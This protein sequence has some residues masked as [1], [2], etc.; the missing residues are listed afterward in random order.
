MVFC[1][2]GDYSSNCPIRLRSGLT[3]SFD[4][5]PGVGLRGKVNIEFYVI[6]AVEFVGFE[7]SFFFS[8]SCGVGQAGVIEG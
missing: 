1:L 2:F 7:F 8:D 5:I 4:N 3:G 6:V